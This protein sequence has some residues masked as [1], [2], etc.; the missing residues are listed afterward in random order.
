MRAA[1]ARSVWASA[2]IDRITRYWTP[3][4]RNTQLIPLQGI[5]LA[6][7]ALWLGVGAIFLAFTY[8][9][10]ALRL[11]RRNGASAAGP[12]RK[13]KP[14]PAAES[15]PIAHPVFSAAASLRQ[16]LS[17]TRI[18]FTETTKNVFFLVLMLAGGLFADLHRQ[19]NH[20]SVMPRLLIP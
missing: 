6:N 2:A 20:R 13:S 1:L 18:Q 19:R 7:R 16:L 5:L 4:Q 17:L 11:S 3:F 15:L 10:F 8:V 9:K 14:V 12:L